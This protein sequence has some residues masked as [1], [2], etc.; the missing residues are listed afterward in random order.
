MDYTDFISYTDC[1]NNK[2]LGKSVKECC[3][4]FKK[5]VNIKSFAAIINSCSAFYMPSISE[6]DKDLKSIFSQIDV[7]KDGKL[8]EK[9]LSTYLA[10]NYNISL[11]EYCQ[12]NATVE[13]LVNAIEGKE[14]KEGKK[15][16]WDFLK[17]RANDILDSF[18][19]RSEE[20]VQRYVDAA[21]SGSIGQMNAASMGDTRMHLFQP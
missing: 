7:N 8:T 18:R 14:E 16:F 2:T 5:G 1:I 19:L 9:E 12:K 13:M 21:D 11:D 6:D 17:S 15:G 4:P 20:D 3:Q 10:K